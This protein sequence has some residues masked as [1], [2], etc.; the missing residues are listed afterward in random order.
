M[1]RRAMIRA[2]SG[3]TALLAIAPR[4]ISGAAFAGM[5]ALASGFAVGLSS[6]LLPAA[7]PAFAQTEA[8]P[9]ALPSTTI[10]P[11][12]GGAPAAAPPSAGGKP[13]MEGGPAESGGG[14]SGMPEEAPPPTAPAPKKHHRVHHH[15]STVSAPSS[16]EVEPAKGKLKL[17]EDAW[18]Y[19]RPAKSAKRVEQVHAGKFITV[20]GTTHHY[21]QVQLKNGATG[22]LPVSA[23]D[24]VRPTDQI[25]QLT[26]DTPV[27]SE[28]NHWAKK[29]SEVH[30]GHK[31]HVIGISLNYMKIRMKDGVEG[32]IS[33]TALE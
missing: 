6:L 5:F 7:K 1:E 16:A 26:S 13:S 30:R 29:V 25:F 27:L 20:T 32:F 10:A 33:T 19:S 31:V 15:T 14:E 17:K 24:L 21:L 23:V 3:R 2:R 22:F 28:P 9:S 12:V 4:A 11:A 18:V 8:A